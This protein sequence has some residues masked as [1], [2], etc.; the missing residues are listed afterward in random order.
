[1]K[2]DNPVFRCLQQ[3]RRRI[4]WQGAA[5]GAAIGSLAAGGTLVAIS[6][7]R[8][9]AGQPHLP[10]P[11]MLAIAA[12]GLLAGVLIG[13]LRAPDH[14]STAVHLDALAQTRNRFTTA[15]ELHGS[16]ARLAA[17][18]F[19]E[20][21]QF[22]DSF[23]PILCL[24]WRIPRA[25]PWLGVPLLCLALLLWN[26]GLQNK[27][28]VLVEKMP[29]R[30]V[31]QTAAMNQLAG[32]L[33]KSGDPALTK[34]ARELKRA[35]DRLAKPQPPEAAL[36]QALR[37]LSTIESLVR[38]AQDSGL[39]AELKAL[40]Q[41]IRQAGQNQAANAMQRGELN[42]AAEHLQKA[43]ADPSARGKLAEAFRSALER[44]QGSQGGEIM[45]QMERASRARQRREQ[46]LRRLAELLQQIGRRQRPQPR[47]G[48]SNENAQRLL[49]MLQE[50]KSNSGNRSDGKPGKDMFAITANLG[51]RSGR[52]P[53]QSGMSASRPGGTPGS[54]NDFATTLSPFGSQQK[55]G[56]ATAAADQLAGVTTEEGESL[57]AVVAAAGGDDNAR[58][59]Y[60]IIHSAAQ[61][62]AEQAVA[63]EKIPLGSRFYVKR[64][65]D[66]IR[67]R[68]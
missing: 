27:P 7:V 44:M 20:C 67:P 9:A 53:D 54:E 31:Q 56:G 3:A 50:I 36:K 1:M 10:A 5:E 65:F 55:S 29:A 28:A 35:A 60:R 14:A 45:E 8:L 49:A 46:A 32:Q 6:G 43:A 34:I 30:V 33:D 47:P 11:W 4:V 66:S 24:P 61:A 17:A 40:A 22:A 15:L 19:E 12:G 41:A 63:H 62:D 2:T 18:A 26:E 57:H 51:K 38:K 39:G 21:T 16:K 52:K 64:Y 59:R 48:L 37:E 68:E 58:Q 25:L 23:D 42:K 13:L